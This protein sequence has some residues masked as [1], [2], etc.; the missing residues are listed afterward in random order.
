MRILAVSNL[1][2]PRVLGGYERSA[3]E[4]C[5]ALRDR[6]HD[7]LVLTSPTERPIAQAG[8]D[9]SLSMLAYLDPQPAHPAIK[10]LVDHRC[11][12]SQRDNTLV[13]LDRIRSFR[14]DVLL[15]FNLVGIGGLALLDLARESGVPWVWNLGDRVPNAMLEGS[16]E[17]VRAIYGGEEEIFDGGRVS[18]VSDVLRREMEDTGVRLPAD[19][20][21]IPRGFRTADVTTR[22]RRGRRRMRFLSAG[23][24]GEEKGT[25]L[26]VEAAGMLAEEVGRRFELRIVGPGDVESYRARVRERGLEKLVRVEGELDHEQLAEQYAWS[27]V[28]LFPGRLHEPFGRVPFEAV[29][30]GSVPI[31]AAGTAASEWFLDGVDS[32][33]VHRDAASFAAAMARA[34]RGEYE[35]PKMAGAGARLLGGAVSFERTIDSHERLL[36][37]VAREFAG[38][39]EA[40]GARVLERDRAALLAIHCAAE[41]PETGVDPS[42]SVTASG[43]VI[44]DH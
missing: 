27:D 7:V 36:R 1:Y 20:Q 37:D 32:V 2:P 39:P 13:L 43:T 5:D 44:L 12:A 34:V 30:H 41:V 18:I 35:L 23:T 26:L 16:I 3:R 29:S 42:D 24:L 8:V 6:G 22:S 40:V 11:M 15:F 33:K 21:V 25:G 38:V 14:P 4:I 31:L 28:F 19:T 9:R 17:E 10:L